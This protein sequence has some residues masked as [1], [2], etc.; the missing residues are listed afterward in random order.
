MQF[1]TRSAFDA[2]ARGIHFAAR[3]VMQISRSKLNEALAHGLG[4]RTHASLCASLKSGPVEPANGFDQA[5]FQTS[6]ARLE[7]WWKAPVL[8]VLAEGHTF[9]IEIEKWPHG[10][11]QRNND[12]YSDVSYHVV[13][14][15]LKGDGAKA[16]AG[17]PFTLPVFGQSITEERF[18]VD[19]GYSY[20]VT[21]G[22]YVSRF[23]KGSQT[24]RSRLEDGRWGGEAFIYG[25][26]EQQDDSPTLET[27]KSDLVSAI[28]PTTSGRVICGVYHPD[29]YDPNARR[30]EITL[31]ARVLDFLNGE[32]LV[33]K[34]P[35]LE[36]RFFVMDDKR[37]N[38]EGIGVIVNGFWGAAV[39]SNG[40]EEVDNPTSLA[41]VQVLMQIAVEER[42]SELGYNRKQA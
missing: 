18:R 35:M 31:D 10:L 24:M 20:R 8:A 7:S 26:A 29:R 33:F 40:V 6:V 22:L 36:K 42:L 17:Q 9:D 19:S 23:R 2:Y 1:S 27:I 41:E 32:P 21:D 15:V 3:K 28:L 34:I 13:I 5:A 16:Q 39:N 38:A 12:H 37:S 4:F 30:I 25:F 11:G 14:N